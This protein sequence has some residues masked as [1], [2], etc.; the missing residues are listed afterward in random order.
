V[1]VSRIGICAI[2]VSGLLYGC[3]GNK[4][5]PVMLAREGLKLA[6]SG[7][8]TPSQ[9]PPQATAKPDQS[10]PPVSATP[11]N[12]DYATPARGNVRGAVPPQPTA[13]PAQSSPPASTPQTHKATAAKDKMRTYVVKQGD[14]LFKIAKQ[15]YGD[16]RKW[17]KIQKANPQIKDPG[18][19]KIGEKLTIPA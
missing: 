4:P 14:T 15:H 3:A 12:N 8:K 18:Q 13:M 7:D 9:A 2:A 10:S 16:G 11:I 5:P 19:L 1:I 17:P 6:A